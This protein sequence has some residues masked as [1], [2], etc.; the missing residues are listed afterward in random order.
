MTCPKC[1]AQNQPAAVFCS[2][3]ANSLR[4][5]PGVAAGLATGGVPIR[6]RTSGMAIAGFVLSFFCSLLGLIF[7]CIGYSECKKSHG[8]VDGAGMALAGIIISLVGMLAGL[9]YF[10][11]IAATGRF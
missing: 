9:G 3:C 10:A 11:A 6:P 8:A 7:S 4:A 5:T 1:G 2:Q